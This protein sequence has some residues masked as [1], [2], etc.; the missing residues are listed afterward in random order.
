MYFYPCSDHVS[1][2]TYG[3]TSCGGPCS[4]PRAQECDTHIFD[5]MKFAPGLGDPEYAITLTTV[6]R[7]DTVA[8]S[9]TDE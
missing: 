7:D 3:C 2:I 6:A 5:V 8:C 1:Y 4:A 9:G